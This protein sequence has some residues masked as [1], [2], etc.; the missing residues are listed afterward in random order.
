[1]IPLTAARWTARVFILVGLGLFA[2]MLV[3]AFTRSGSMSIGPDG[4]MITSFSEAETSIL[5]MLFSS[6]AWSLCVAVGAQ[7]LVSSAS[8]ARAVIRLGQPFGFA[9]VFAGPMLWTSG[10][11]SLTLPLVVAGVL[12]A[13][14]ARIL[15]FAFFGA[16][17]VRRAVD[18]GV[19]EIKGAM[20][21]LS[22]ASPGPACGGGPM[23]PPPEGPT[24]D[25]G[26]KVP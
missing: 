22:Q 16:R 11:R 24:P 10:S 9:L 17:E 13:V 6:T 19:R 12:V 14:A 26:L 3:Y 2:G 1:M 23:S 15:D 8:A 20:A 21:E 4:S 18:E 7:V 25:G 5:G